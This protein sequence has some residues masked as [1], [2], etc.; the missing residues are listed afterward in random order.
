MSYAASAVTLVRALSA[1]LTKS[2]PVAAIIDDCLRPRVPDDELRSAAGEIF[3]LNVG[4]DL[5]EDGHYIA[6]RVLGD[7]WLKIGKKK[8]PRSRLSAS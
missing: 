1:A 8:R 2:R 4:Y 3:R 6:R 5:T 7:G